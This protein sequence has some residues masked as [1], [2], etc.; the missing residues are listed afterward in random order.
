[1]SESAQELEQRI[2]SHLDASDFPRAATVAIEGYGP[3][4]LGFLASVLRDDDAAYDVFSQ[5]SEDL[6]RG[7]AGFRRASSMRTW[8]YALAWNAAQRW[9]GE[10]YRRHVR[11]LETAEVSKL[12]DSIRLSTQVRA[13][14]LASKLRDGL[15]ADELTLVILRVDKELA[16]KEVAQV[17]STPEQPVDVPALRKRFERVCEKLRQHAAREGL[18]P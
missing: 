5:F 18:T 4:I 6:W 16:W 17:L 13:K 1:M 9:R 11:R 15:D 8:A 2:A 10:A 7:I 14:D 3:Q 12:V